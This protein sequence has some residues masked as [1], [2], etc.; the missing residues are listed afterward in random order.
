MSGQLPVNDSIP[1]ILTKLHPPLLRRN[2]FPR[3]RLAAL[4]RQAAERRLT[5][6][7]AGAGYGKTTLIASSLAGT[8]VPLVWYSLSR[9]DRDIVTFFSY[10]AEGLD[11]TLP[12]GGFAEAVRLACAA[13]KKP[14]AQPTAFV[15]ACVN[16]LA[17][18]RTDDFFIVLDDFQLVDQIPEICHALDLLVSHAP[19]QAHF[20][21][22]TRTAPAIS[23]LARLRAEGE[24]LEIGEADL[25]FTADEAATLFTQCLKLKLPEPT[26]TALA[27]QI[28]GWALGLL[29]AGQSI[30]VRGQD[31]VSDCLSELATDR[32]VLFEYLTEEV[33]RQ[34]PPAVVD[35]LTSSAILSRLEPAECDAALGRSDSAIRLHELEQHCLFVV[36]T[37][38]GWLR[39]HRLFRQFLLQHLAGDPERSEA[40]HRRAAAYFEGQQNFEAAIFHWLEAGDYRPAATLI[41]AVSAEMV[42]AG[43]FDTLS[44][45]LGRLP[46][47]EFAEFPE[48]WIRWGQMCE[49]HGQWDHALEHYERA[50]Q[51][52]TARG[53][54]LG[55][56]DV[57]RSKGHILNWRKGKHAEAERLHREALGYVGEEHR[58]KRAAL[59]GGL[60]RDQLSAGNTI[61]AQA[62]Y[63]RRSPSMRLRPTAR[64]S[65]TR[66]S[67]PARG[68]ITVWAISRTRCPCSAAPNSWH[69]S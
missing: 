14:P 52:Y 56:S 49:A 1:L 28:E 19:P 13:D 26:T 60:G 69:S 41:A 59:L 42:C 32:R 66:C 39:Y 34:Q 38:D 9:S 57:L 53:D 50:A 47:S 15:A 68:C 40:L 18:A 27:E 37:K 48:L 33:L 63:R 65:S 67:T 61:A 7:C 45:W 8:G 17:G 62:L 36:R 16:R 20:V 43:R 22:A 11:R 35:F 64:A 31:E 30:K 25:K 21:V 44:F 58:R 3:E 6:V 4:V 55:L 29:M 10:L 5:L 24:A 51:G 54:L 46:R 12:G 2:T 23:C